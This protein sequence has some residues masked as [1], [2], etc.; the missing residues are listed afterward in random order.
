MLGKILGDKY[1]ILFATSGKEAIAI[2]LSRHPDMI[3]LDII[4]PDMDGYTVCYK[5]REH[6]AT[7]D[8]PV[9]FVTAMEQEHHEVVGL[10]MG[11]VDYISK[12]VNP[13]IARLRIKNILELSQA[14]IYFK[15]L[16]MVD[17]LT[18]IYNRRYFDELFTKEWQRSIR[19]QSPLSIILMDIDFFKGYNDHYGHVEGDTCL[20]R[21]AKALKGGVIR[22]TDTLA[23]YGGEEFVCLMA[24]TDLSGLAVMA[25]KLRSVVVNLKIPHAASQ[26]AEH[27]TISLGGKTVIPK[28]SMSQE[29]CL[30]AVDENLYKAKAQGR[31]CHVCDLSE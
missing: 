25:D 17:G 23:R 10:E 2:A 5:I 21:I 18:G 15:R 1:R 8:I 29:A 26:I 14:R 3:L 13:D 30:V 31:N 12:P 28:H 11:A 6:P 4:M 24:E 22:T 7:Q 16:A 27:V 9:I 19:A 20:K